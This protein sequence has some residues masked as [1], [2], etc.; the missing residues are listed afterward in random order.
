MNKVRFKKD[1]IQQFKIIFS[2]SIESQSFSLGIGQLSIHLPAAT[3]LSA[4]TADA[5]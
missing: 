3:W 5:L 2:S 4:S 1:P